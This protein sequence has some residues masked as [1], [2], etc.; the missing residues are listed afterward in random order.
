MLIDSEEKGES[1]PEVSLNLPPD[2]LKDYKKT[3]EYAKKYNM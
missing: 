3:Y 2:F 1:M